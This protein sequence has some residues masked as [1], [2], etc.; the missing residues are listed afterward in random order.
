[1]ASCTRIITD[2]E[3]FDSRTRDNGPIQEG[4]HTRDNTLHYQNENNLHGNDEIK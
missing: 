3:N 1:M 4:S 2:Q